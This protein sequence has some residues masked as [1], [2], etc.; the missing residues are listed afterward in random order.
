MGVQSRLARLVGVGGG[1]AA[2]AVLL[3][4]GG[5][6]RGRRPIPSFRVTIVL[7]LPWLW[8]LERK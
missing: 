8:R 3:Q 5:S 6:S 2:M 1:G 7:E 4:V